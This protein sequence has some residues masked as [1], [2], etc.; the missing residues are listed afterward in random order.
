[1]DKLKRSPKLLIGPKQNIHFAEFVVAPEV[2]DATKVEKRVTVGDIKK[3]K[4][5]FKV[6]VVVVLFKTPLAL[7][8][9][10]TKGNDVTTPLH[11]LKV[12]YPVPYGAPTVGNVK[13]VL[14]KVFDYLYA[15][16][17]PQFVN[18]RTN[19][20][21][22]DIASADTN[23]ILKPGDFRLTSYEWGV[24]YSAMLTA[25]EA[26][27]DA[28]YT[29]YTKDRLHFIADAVPSFAALFK[30]FPKNNNPLRAPVDPRA[31]DDAGAVCAAMIKTLR[32]GG[33]ANLRPVINNY[34]NY[35]STKEFRLTDGTLARNRPQPNTIWLDDLY[36]AVPALAQ[37][38]KLT[39]DKKYYDDGVKQILQFS[40]RMFNKQNNLYMHGW[41][42]EM[43]EHRNFIGHVQMVGR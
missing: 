3:I 9:Q 43:E 22:T 16:T 23:A 11:A 20:A 7:Y 37:M 33:N 10:T 38:G 12:A 14:D 24:T 29:N 42:Q 31:L 18:R 40:K 17:P 1:M 6:L 35:I 15:V 21:V 34:I 25:G 27:S 32:S 30:K 13:Q 36:M 19:A 2:C 4:Y 8:A 41:V 26:T 39:G 5:F 28:R